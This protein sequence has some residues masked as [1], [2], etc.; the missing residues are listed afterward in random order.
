MGRH[1]ACPYKFREGRGEHKVR[2][3]A[4]PFLTL[5]AA[6]GRGLWVGGIWAL[7][8]KRCR[9]CIRV[10][11]RPV[12]APTLLGPPDR[13]AFLSRG[14]RFEVLRL[15]A[16][17]TVPARVVAP[18]GCLATGRGAS[19]Y[20]FGPWGKGAVD[21]AVVRFHSPSASDLARLTLLGAKS[22]V[23]KNGIGGLGCY[24]ST[25]LRVFEP[26]PRPSIN[27]PPCNIHSEVVVNLQPNPLTPFPTREGG[28][29]AQ[30][31][32]PLRKTKKE[33][34]AGTRPAPTKSHFHWKQFF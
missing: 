27:S 14:G 23:R 11:Y 31:I 2:P 9:C 8:V 7:H 16:G 34:R 21:R 29:W 15:C 10:L 24:P 1:K 3:Y 18:S 28:E 30:C 4:F 25:S 26:Q 17:S 12:L 19:C 6:R 13:P 33:R 20:A 32:V 5:L 22:R